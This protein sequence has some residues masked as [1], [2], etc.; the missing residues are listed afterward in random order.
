MTGAPRRTRVA[1]CLDSFELGGTELNAVRTAEQV[2]RTR[3]DLSFI[4]LSDRGPLA[5]RVRDAGIPIHVFP[6]QGFFSLQMLRSAR[7]LV[8]HLRE[9]HIDVV[10]AHDIYSNIFAVPCARMARVP[11]VIASRRWWHAANRAVYLTLNRAT[12]HLAHRVLANSEAV[13]RLV[14]EEGMAR[15]RV[16]VIPNF[17]ED[18]AFEAPGEAVLAGWRA[19]CGIAADDEVIGIIANLH[20]IKDQSTL[21]RALPRVLAE[22]GRARLVLVGDG[23]DRRALEALATSLGVRER[24]TFAGRRPQR[25]TMHWLFDVS[26]LS[27]RG[28]GFPNSIVEGMAAGRPLVATAVGGVPD[29]VVDGETGFLVPPGSPEA[30]AD[31]IVALL[32][33]PALR[34][35]MGAAGARR[36][37]SEFHASA[38]VRRLEAL[39]DD[40]LARS[41]R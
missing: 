34:A 26:V 27:S 36:A 4:A 41:R 1:Y 2:D 39:Y 21:L 32:R 22:R 29:V 14:V 40:F 24:V 13:G 18:Y 37:R 17:V 28:E 12:Y 15:A 20:A 10:H 35:A 9:A 6:L 31:R 25:P 3:F 38:V 16:V 23:E 5:A 30:L 11:M 7:R 8:R 19:D 33:D